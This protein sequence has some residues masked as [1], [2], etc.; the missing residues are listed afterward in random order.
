L[1]QEYDT[2][3]T[4]ICL[5]EYE[6][7]RQNRD[8]AQEWLKEASTRLER[9][10]STGQYHQLHQRLDEIYRSLGDDKANQATVD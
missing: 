8:Q 6:L 2:I 9:Y 5:A 1:G 10:A 4:T 3:R 7:A